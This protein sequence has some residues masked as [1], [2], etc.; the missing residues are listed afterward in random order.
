VNEDEEAE[1]S[2]R[3]LDVM[4][5][6]QK[7]A[8]EALHV[9]DISEVDPA[10]MQ[11]AV[12]TLSEQTTSLVEDE[13]GEGGRRRKLTTSDTLSLVVYNSYT[14]KYVSTGSTSNEEYP[15]TY[16]VEPYR[17]STLELQ[18]TQVGATYRWTVDGHVHGYGTSTEALFT[19]IGYHVV[20]VEEMVTETDGSITTNKLLVKVMCKYV[21]R[22]IRALT[23]A[24]REA[25][26]SAIQVIQHVPT[27]AGRSIYGSKYM[28]KDAFTRV[29]LYYGG[30]MDCDHWH[31]VIY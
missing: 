27:V 23:N 21:R 30:A 15:W 17:A 22:E 24:D 29:H 12:Q 11:A 7:Q 28:S 5:K 31:Q 13:D 3:F 26:L 16:M 8:L 10:V 25:W 1:H 4:P 9:S 19:E 2:Q 20:K 14:K 18:N 6:L